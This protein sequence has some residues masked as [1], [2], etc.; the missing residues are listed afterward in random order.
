VGK[1]NAGR[2]NFTGGSFG[3]WPMEEQKFGMAAMQ[4]GESLKGQL[5]LRF[6]G[7]VRGG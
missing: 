2:G 1:M 5:L 4:A 7:P 6:S 3:S